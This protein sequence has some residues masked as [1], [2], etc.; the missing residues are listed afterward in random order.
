VSSETTL[1]KYS[2]FAT[3]KIQI[4]MTGTEEYQKKY[5]N[6]GTIKK[7]AKSSQ[8]AVSTLLNLDARLLVEQYET[9]TNMVRMNI[10]G[11]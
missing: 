6:A 5:G 4:A 8:K 3:F 7:D 9:F 1:F 10:I 2:T 11:A